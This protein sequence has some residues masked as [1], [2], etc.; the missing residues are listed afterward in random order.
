MVAHR[1]LRSPPGW[2]SAT[3]TSSSTSAPSRRRSTSA[4]TRTG[5]PKSGPG[6]S[7]GCRGRPGAR[8]AS[9]GSAPRARRPAATAGRQRSKRD[10][11]RMQA[12]RARL[13]QQSPDREEV[14]VPAPVL[15]H[16]EHQAPARAP[17]P[18]A[19]GRRGGRG[20]RLVDHHR[21]PGARGPRGPGARAPGSGW[22]RRPG[23][24]PRPP[25]TA[26]P[27]APPAAPRDGRAPPPR[28]GSGR[29]DDRAT[30]IPLGSAATSGA[31]K[32][33]A[34]EAV[35]EDGDAEVGEGHAGD[36]RERAGPAGG[37]RLF[38]RLCRFL[39]PRHGL[40]LSPP[41]PSETSGGRRS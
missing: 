10:S 23:P 18:P 40:L 9:R 17:R 36:H 31:W 15:E 14:T 30:R 22:P 38:S 32:T 1:W 24:A 8:R 35:P 7:G 4:Y 39:H 12:A 25:P 2:A 11:S 3:K 29:G 26:R 16:G 6:R 41:A 13:G 33:A 5:G 27:P 20:Q 34:G 37:L 28:G 19:P 21:Q